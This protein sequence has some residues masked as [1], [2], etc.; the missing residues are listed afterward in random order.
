MRFSDWFTDKYM[1]RLNPDSSSVPGDGIRNG[2]GNDN[3]VFGYQSIKED[4]LPFSSTSEPLR[5]LD[6]KLEAS[7]KSMGSVAALR[8]LVRSHKH[9]SLS[10]VGL[11]LLLLGILRFL[12]MPL[13]GYQ[14]SSAQRRALVWPFKLN[15]NFLLLQARKM[16][17]MPRLVSN[18]QASLIF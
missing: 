5:G 4:V 6:S 18:S 12:A 11:L 3:C 8:E 7:K 9:F 1:S 16:K 13:I 17:Y 14:Y 2:F 10:L 15:H